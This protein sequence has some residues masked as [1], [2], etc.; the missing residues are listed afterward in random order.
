MEKQSK[1]VETQWKPMEKQWKHMESIE[2]N[3]Q[4]NEIPWESIRNQLWKSHDKQWEIIE[5]LGKS[6]RTNRQ[7][8]KSTGRSIESS[9]RGQIFRRQYRAGETSCCIEWLCGPPGCTR[10]IQVAAHWLVLNDV[11]FHFVYLYF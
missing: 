9:I 6:L 4:S 7:A 8:M 10:A 5:N 11:C 2:S 1:P 3:R